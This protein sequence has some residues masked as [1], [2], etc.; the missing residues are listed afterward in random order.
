MLNSELILDPSISSADIFVICL[1][2]NNILPFD[3][4]DE[5]YFMIICY[6]M[7]VTVIIT[8]ILVND[9]IIEER[10]DRLHYRYLSLINYLCQYICFYNQSSII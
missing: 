1:N 7:L 9:N 10:M 4:R 6:V 3:F 5:N 8:I 2:K